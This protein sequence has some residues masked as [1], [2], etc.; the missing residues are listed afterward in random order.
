MS[1]FYIYL[2][3]SKSLNKYHVGSTSKIEERLLKHN[4][5]H[6]GFTGTTNDWQLAYFEEFATKFEA[7]KR[8]KI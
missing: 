8:E 6:K 2:L 5:N 1:M 4:S 7:F 3:F